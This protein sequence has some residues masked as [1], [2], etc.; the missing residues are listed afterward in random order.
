MPV[1]TMLCA[2][3]TVGVPEKTPPVL[4]VMPAGTPVPAQVYAPARPAA[5]NV[6]VGEYAVLNSGSATVVGLTV[7]AGHDTE[8]L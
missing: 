4:T 2:P 1:T 8:M 6:T 7:S 5:V 3:L